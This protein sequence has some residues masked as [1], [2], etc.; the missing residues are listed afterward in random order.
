MKIIA[1]IFYLLFFT[2][3]IHAQTFVVFKGDTINR[4]DTKGLKQGVWKKFYRTDSLFSVTT[5]KDNKQTGT[6]K[7]FYESGKIKSTL[8]WK[9]PGQFAFAES[10]FEEGKKMSDGYY[11]NEQKDST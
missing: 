3:I 8:I 1:V 2:G 11:L 10:F 4:K 9:K 7:F 6:T 5:F